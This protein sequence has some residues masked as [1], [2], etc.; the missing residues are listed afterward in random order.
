MSFRP[1]RLFQRLY[2]LQRLNTLQRALFRHGSGS[3]GLP[4]GELL[5]AGCAGFAALAAL[6]LFLGCLL[7]NVLISVEPVELFREDGSEK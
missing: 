3:S 1:L 7:R 2:I 6:A 4:R 5:W